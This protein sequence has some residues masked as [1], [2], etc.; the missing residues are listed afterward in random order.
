MSAILLMY[1]IDRQHLPAIEHEDEQVLLE[2]GRPVAED[3]DW[4]GYCMLYTLVYLDEQDIEL[5][6]A[7][8]WTMLTPADRPLLDRLTPQAHGAGL[9]AFLVESLGDEDDE[10]GDAEEW[11][12]E[13]AA[14]SLRVLH[15]N[16]ERLA[17]DEVLLVH[18]A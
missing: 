13:A 6:R 4:S 10:Q 15:D 17:G 2:H 3:Y 5:G 12:G 11:A 1:V 9:A 7:G 16:L 8:H 14:D 18:I